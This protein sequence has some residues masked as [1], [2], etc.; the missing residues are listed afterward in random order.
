M[1]I[2]TLNTRTS[3][4]KNKQAFNLSSFTVNLPTL[5][6]NMKHNHSWL[7]GDLISMILLNRTDKQILLTALHER[8][9]VNFFKSKDSIT[10]QIIEGKLK[11]YTRKE[12][13]ILNKGQLLTLL[14]NTEYN[15]TT[16][17]ETVLLLTIETG[18]LKTY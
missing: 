4:I 8:T 12:S 5:I 11:F 15:L 16:I 2:E 17:E 9:E 6:E 18:L 7:K 14:E 1:E 13:G 3:L 10:F